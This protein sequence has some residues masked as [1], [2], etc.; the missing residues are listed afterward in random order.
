MISLDNGESRVIT[1]AN[2]VIIRI[3]RLKEIINVATK[4]KTTSLIVYL[5]PDVAKESLLS[6]NFPQAAATKIKSPSL[7]VYLKPDIAEESLLAKNVK[8]KLTYTSLH[9]MTAAMEIWYDPDPQFM[10]VLDLQADYFS[11]T[12]QAY[13]TASNKDFYSA[14]SSLHCN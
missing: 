13:A 7:T 10:Y 11:N 5:E 6:K 12:S 2:P 3:N 9:T 1:A 14:F 4:I 8:Q